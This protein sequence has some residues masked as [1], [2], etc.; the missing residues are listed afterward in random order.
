MICIIDNYML[1]GCKK[2]KKYDY[3]RALTRGLALLLDGDSDEP[4][5]IVGGPGVCPLVNDLPRRGESSSP[6][7]RAAFA[8]PFPRSRGNESSYL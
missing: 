2:Y 5:R 7:G 8:F 3:W 6:A 4:E 1:T